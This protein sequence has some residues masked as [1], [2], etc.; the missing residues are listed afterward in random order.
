MIVIAGFLLGAL[1][2]TFLAYRRKGNRKD[3]A[4]YAIA[5]GIVFAIIGLFATITIDRMF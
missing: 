2:G 3:I 4:Q 1:W 5:F